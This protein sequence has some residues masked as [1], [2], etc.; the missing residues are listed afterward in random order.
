MLH[1]QD[2][3][4]P[5]SQVFVISSLFPAVR[6]KVGHRGVYGPAWKSTPGSA[7]LGDVQAPEMELRV[8]TFQNYIIWPGHIDGRLLSY[9][10]VAGKRG[11]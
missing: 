2:T 6:S 10:T 11:V 7:E 4:E 3:T 8:I 5:G 1:C 9:R